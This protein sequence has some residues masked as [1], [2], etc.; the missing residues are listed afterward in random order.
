MSSNG[1]SERKLTTWA[2]QHRKKKAA[3][4][5]ILSKLQLDNYGTMGELYQQ[6]DFNWLREYC[7]LP[8]L[9]KDAWKALWPHLAEIANFERA[10]RQL[11]QQKAIKLPP[12]LDAQRNSK[13]RLVR[14]GISMELSPT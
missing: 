5:Q 11:V 1:S 9:D 7:G 10:I 14:Q 12:H 8:Y 13:E 4:L 3:A 6:A 2:K